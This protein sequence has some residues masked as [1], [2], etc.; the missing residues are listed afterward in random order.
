MA[1]PQE[2]STPRKSPVQIGSVPTPRYSLL[3][4]PQSPNVFPNRHATPESP[5]IA[6]TSSFPT[7]IRPISAQIPSEEVPVGSATRAH[8]IMTPETSP[9]TVQQ[10]ERTPLPTRINKVLFSTSPPA[11]VTPSSLSPPTLPSAT[12]ISK[13]PSNTQTQSYTPDAGTRPRTPSRVQSQ[14]PSQLSSPFMAKRS[15][16]TVP[17]SSSQTKGPVFIEDVFSV[18]L[19]STPGPSRN[20][21]PISLPS[22]SAQ[23]PT[24]AQAQRPQPMRDETKVPGGELERIRQ[25]QIAEQAVVEARRPDYFVREGKR[26]AESLDDLRSVHVSNPGFSANIHPSGIGIMDSPNK[27]RRIKLYTSSSVNQPSSSV[28]VVK[29]KIKLFPDLK[30]F[31][32]TSEESFEESLM[33]G[34]YGRYRTAE[35]VRQPQPIP[36]EVLQAHQVR[37]GQGVANPVATGSPIVKRLE[38]QSVAASVERLEDSSATPLS[39]HSQPSQPPTEKEL[40]KRKRLDAFRVLTTASSLPNSSSSPTTVTVNDSDNA[41]VNKDAGSNGKVGSRKE[42]PRKLYPVELEGRGRVLVDVLPGS[43]ISAYGSEDV[44]VQDTTGGGK[45]KKRNMVTEK[46]EREV[47]PEYPYGLVVSSSK[48]K[49][50]LGEL[51]TTSVALEKPNWPDTEF[52]WRLREEE[53]EEAKI[54]DEEERLK[55][56]ERFLDRDDD[57]DSTDHED[58]PFAALGGGKG[59]AKAVEEDDELL[60]S[61]QWGVVYHEDKPTPFKAGRG[62]MVPLR[63]NTTSEVVK[64]DAEEDLDDERVPVRRKR[65]AM[66]FPSDP[67]DARAALLS[68]RSVR[69][70]SFRKQMEAERKRRRMLREARGGDINEDDLMEE[71]E[72]VPCICNGAGADFEDDEARG[73]VQCDSCDLWYHFGCMGMH[74]D[75]VGDDD[76]W[77]CPECAPRLEPEPA[78]EPVF[79]PTE[80]TQLIRRGLV[81]DPMLSNSRTTRDSPEPGT[82]RSMA[83]VPPLS[84]REQGILMTPKTPT[85]R[86]SRVPGSDFLDG[87]FSSSS[88]P[89]YSYA[90]PGSSSS[91]FLTSASTRGYPTTPRHRL[92]RT[93]PRIHGQDTLL[94]SGNRYEDSPIFDPLSTPSRGIKFNVPPPFTTPTRKTSNGRPGGFYTPSRRSFGGFGGPGFLSSALDDKGDNWLGSGYGYGGDESPIRRKK[95]SLSSDAVMKSK[96]ALDG[97]LASA[98]EPSGGLADDFEASFGLGRS[99]GRIKELD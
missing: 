48:K 18:G 7:Q 77:F 67:A 65:S 55:W 4:T 21:Q 37:H 2:P 59:K 42:P 61:M 52:P 93:E 87:D 8:Q 51:K 22:S 46:R 82:D 71:E 6:H 95:F 56:V 29:D 33:A 64:V 94:G 85:R 43:S 13:P 3:P 98:P 81:E 41:F 9:F 24:Q 53:R 12:P 66:Y 20:T 76:K 89:R 15:V 1:A 39:D 19:G 91:S 25:R 92:S 49:S 40:R 31:Q 23:H 16:H 36:I 30:L 50:S 11:T 47:S 97:L 83:P 58:T 35:W 99:P 27:G 73:V 60:P 5:T 38:D 79:V 86:R 44:L 84:S 62:K 54:R 68:K 78:E 70:L 57:S 74:S 96:R 63:A 88:T 26:K 75:D 28:D 10:D 17:V 34:G 72:E 45:R 14:T 69:A 90:L 80:E 32:E